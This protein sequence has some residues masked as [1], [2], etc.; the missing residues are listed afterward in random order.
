MYQDV[1]KMYRIFHMARLARCIPLGNASVSVPSTMAT[2][3]SV[4]LVAM[5][6]AKLKVPANFRAL[7]GSIDTWTKLYDWLYPESAAAACAHAFAAWLIEQTD[8]IHILGV[9]TLHHI[10]AEKAANDR[11]PLCFRLAFYLVSWPR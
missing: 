11:T 2:S 10:V 1:P 7:T 4:S 8:Y 6:T 5:S 3:G 9:Y